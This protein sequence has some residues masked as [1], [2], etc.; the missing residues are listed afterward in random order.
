MNAIEQLLKVARAYAEIE[1][2]GLSTVSSRVF[3]DGKRLEAIESGKDM[4]V[5]ILERAMQW[6]SDNWPEGTW[7]SGVPRPR[8]SDSRMAERARA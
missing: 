8:R 1:R 4:R 7:P 5:R 3:N 2:I 6:F